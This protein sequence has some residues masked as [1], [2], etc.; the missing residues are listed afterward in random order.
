MQSLCFSYEP[1][2]NNPFFMWAV[3][4]GLCGYGALLQ[5]ILL[6]LPRSGNKG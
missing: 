4:S 1:T 3:I 2:P 5:G 6:F